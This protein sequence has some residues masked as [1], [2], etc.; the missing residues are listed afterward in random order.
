[1]PEVK[2]ETL[3]EVLVILPREAVSKKVLYPT[4]P[5]LSVAGFQVI[6]ADVSVRLVIVKFEGAVGA[7][8]SITFEVLN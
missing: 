1:V 7:L 8:V 5:T 4:T 2:L 6:V 3:V